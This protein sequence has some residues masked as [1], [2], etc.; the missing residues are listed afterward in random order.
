MNFLIGCIILMAILILIPTGLYV[1]GLDDIHNRH[2]KLTTDKQYIE[3][4][5]CNDLKG[6]ETLLEGV[7]TFNVDQLKTDFLNLEKEKGCN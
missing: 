1:K 4:L 2:I 6:N 7:V 5:N 3:T